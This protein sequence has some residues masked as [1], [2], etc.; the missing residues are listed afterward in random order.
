MVWPPTNPPAGGNTGGLVFNNLPGGTYGSSGSIQTPETG[1]ENNVPE[2]N[3][4]P[5][6]NFLTGALFPFFKLLGNPCFWPILILILMLLYFIISKYFAKDPFY[7]PIIIVV[8]LIIF[9]AT[10]RSWVGKYC[11]AWYCCLWPLLIAILLF[12]YIIMRKRKYK[13]K[14]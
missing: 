2:T 6:F 12:V 1:E 8:L 7:W 3:E 4:N 11:S 14:L 9:F 13:E 5:P 10:Y